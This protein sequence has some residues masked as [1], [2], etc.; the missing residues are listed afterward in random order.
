L[1]EAGTLSLFLYQCRS[2]F[3]WN[4]Q[5]TSAVRLGFLIDLILRVTLWYKLLKT[6]RY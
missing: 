5:D 1:F 2:Y 6:W 4:L 3:H